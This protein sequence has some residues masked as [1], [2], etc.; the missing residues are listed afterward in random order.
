MRDTAFLTSHRIPQ[1]SLGID[2]FVSGFEEKF[3]KLGGRKEKEADV[4]ASANTEEKKKGF[5]P[6]ALKSSDMKAKERLSEKR[7]ERERMAEQVRR[8]MWREGEGRKAR[9]EV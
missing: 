8:V 1:E 4:D 2:K 5:I 6:Q 9:E 7:A 3:E